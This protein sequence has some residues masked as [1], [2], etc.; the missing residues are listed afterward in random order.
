MRFLRRLVTL[1]DLLISLSLF[2]KWHTSGSALLT[3]IS[4]KFHTP[5]PKIVPCTLLHLTFQGDTSSTF[6]LVNGRTAN[7]FYF[8]WL[9]NL[10]ISEIS[11]NFNGEKRPNVTEFL[12]RNKVTNFVNTIPNRISKHQVLAQLWSGHVQRDRGKSERFEGQESLHTA[13]GS[14]SY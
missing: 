11:I 1:T 3:S 7:G 5:Y 4:A 2:S 12:H 13:G 6:P 14:T 8:L 9:T 10:T